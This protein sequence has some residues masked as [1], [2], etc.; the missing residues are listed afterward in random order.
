MSHFL[1]SITTFDCKCNEKKGVFKIIRYQRQN[2]YISHILPVIRGKYRSHLVSFLLP[3]QFTVVP[4]CLHR[5]SEQL[6]LFLHVLFMLEK[7]L[8]SLVL[9]ESLWWQQSNKKL[10]TGLAFA[11][12]SPP[13]EAAQTYSGTGY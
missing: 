5:S 12:T 4:S 8:S 7:N 2:H 11:L 9:M 3:D 1:H 13:S 6:T 10:L